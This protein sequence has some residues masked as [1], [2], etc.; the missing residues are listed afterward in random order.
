MSLS[1]KGPAPHFDEDAIDHSG[2]AANGG[3][4]V[5]GA[6]TGLADKRHLPQILIP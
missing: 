5:T 4:A 1:G 6:L 3:R 2:A